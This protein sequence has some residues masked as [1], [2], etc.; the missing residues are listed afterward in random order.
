VAHFLRHGVVCWGL[1]ARVQLPLKRPDTQSVFKRRC[2]RWYR[3]NFAMKKQ[4]TADRN[5]SYRK[6]IARQ[7]LSRSDGRSIRNGS[8]RPRPLSHCKIWLLTMIYGGMYGSLKMSSAGAQPLKSR[9]RSWS[10]RNTPSRGSACRI[11][12]VLV[13]WYEHMYGYSPEKNGAFPR[14]GISRSLN[15]IDWS[16]DRSGTYDFLSDL[17]WSWVSDITAISIEKRSFLCSIC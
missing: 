5:V 17:W 7:H 4:E 3:H 15:V 10:H 12:S 13:K 8:S 11:W 1:F 14:I 9:E 16:M 2:L 6:Q